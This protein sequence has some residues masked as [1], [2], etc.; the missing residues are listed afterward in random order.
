MFLSRRVLARAGVLAFGALT[1]A[2]CSDSSTAP[3]P[4]TPDQLQS[5]GESAAMEIESAMSSITAQDVMNTNGGAPSFSR[6][7]HTAPAMIRGLSLNRYAMSRSTTDISQ[8]GVASQDPPVDTD[9]DLVPDN[10][11]VTFSLPACHFADASDTYD[12]TGV[13]RVSDPQPAAAGMSLSFALDNFKLA[14]SGT[15]GSGYVSR[16]GSASVSVTTGGLSQSATW[17]DNAVLTGVA[18]ASD[19]INWTNTFVAAEGQSIT[20][21]RSLPDGAYSPNGSVTI[22]QGN[23]QASFSVTTID[24]LQYSASCAAGVAEGTSLSP[25][26]AGRVRVAVSNQ[27]NSGY[28]DVTYSGCNS[29]TVTLVQ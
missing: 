26:S 28:V 1:L 7:P 8:C 25:F 14:F 19:N 5:V 13:L 12:V 29:A 21:G 10:F 4:V 6:V 9:G 15:N 27:E 22:H 2:A 23:R 18:S 16:N 24:P 17:T 3:L 11:S 20:A